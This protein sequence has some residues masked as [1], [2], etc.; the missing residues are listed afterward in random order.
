M[1]LEAATYIS[2]LVAT[3]PV[4]ATDPRSQGD[5][6]LRLLKT[7]L[8]NT[9]PAITGAVTTTHGELNQLHG[10]VLQSIGSGALGAPAYSFAGD[11]DTGIYRNG[12]NDMRF[13]AGGQIMVSATPTG[14]DVRLYD[15][16]VGAPSLLWLTDVDTGFYR[17]AAN[18]FRATAGG[19]EVCA[20]TAAGTRVLAPDGVAGGPSFAF[21]ADP[22]T[23]IWRITT[24]QMSFAV[25]GVERARIA[26]TFFFINGIPIQGSDGALGAPAYSFDADTDTGMFRN[27]SGLN[28]VHSGKIFIQGTDT[29]VW[30]GQP[31]GASAVTLYGGLIVANTVTAATANTGASGAPP[32]QVAGYL[33]VDINGVGSRKI[34]YYAT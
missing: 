27:V 8:Q 3:N 29:N 10:G 6:H 17:N 5:D 1:G 15:G 20:F 13:V 24:N 18:D 30:I 21:L 19:V 16:A 32:A 28:L 12:A 26:P 14:A 31:S 25:G 33:V 22:D 4:G 7:T 23:G 11:T 34:P 2:Q 9:F